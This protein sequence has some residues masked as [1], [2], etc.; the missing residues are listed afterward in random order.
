MSGTGRIGHGVGRWLGAL[1]LLLFVA[2]MIA[3]LFF[4]VVN[5]F[6]DAAYSVFPPK[7]VSLRWYRNL[8]KIEDFFVA[9]RNSVIIALAAMALSITLGTAIA[10]AIVRGRWVRRE[11]IQSLFLTPLLVPRL[12]IGIAVFIA[13]IKAA[14]Y[15]SFLSIILA[16]SVL[17]LPYVVSILVANLLQVQRVQEEAAMDLGANAWQTFRLATLPQISRGLIVVAIFA[18]IVS[19]DE[20]DIAL[21]LTRSQN[22]TVP[23]RMFLYMQEADNPTMAALS[24]LLIAAAAVAVFAIARIARRADL[25]TLM[26]RRTH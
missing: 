17:L 15:P 9:I 22:M 5:S 25:I 14:L 6:N 7:G 8:F 12:V 23:I 10:L 4:I 24:T 11:T 3:P 18:F 13:A 20:F 19:F 1:Y 26:R 16:D 21:F 2:F